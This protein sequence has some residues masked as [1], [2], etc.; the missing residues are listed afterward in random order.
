[1]C[2]FTVD[3][4]MLSR[5]PIAAFPAPSSASFATSSSRALRPRSISSSSAEARS[6][7][8]AGSWTWVS[9]SRGWTARSAPAEVEAALEAPADSR[10]LGTA[11]TDAELRVLRLLDSDLTF[12]EIAA[13]LDVSSDTVKSHARRAY[14]RRGVNSP[15]A[16]GAAARE[17]GLLAGD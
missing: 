6:W 10:L 7:R 13:E 14:R 8:S 4:E 17:R 15:A 1:M 16:A 2:F 3:W 9:S 5:C 12:R 11:P